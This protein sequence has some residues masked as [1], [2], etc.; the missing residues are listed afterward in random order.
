MEALAALSGAPHAAWNHPTLEHYYPLVAAMAA[1][2][3]APGTRIHKHTAFD[4]FSLDAYGWGIDAT[5]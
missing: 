4:I 1:A 3:G 2:G 5:S